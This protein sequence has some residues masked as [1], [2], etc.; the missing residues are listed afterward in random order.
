MTFPVFIDGEWRESQSVGTFNA[1]NPTTGESLSEQYPI[2]SEAELETALQAGARAAMG[3]RA[4]PPEAIADF[5]EAY[6]KAI[7]A[8][9]D[10]LVEMAFTETA[11][12][13]EPR[14]RTTEIPRTTN[15]LRQAAA[16][17]RERSWCMATIDS[18]ANIRSKYGPLGGPV[19]VMGPNNFPYAFN[20]I[21]GG[22]FAA[23]LAAGNPVIAKAHTAHPATTRLLAEAAVEALQASKLPRGAIQ[24]VYHMPLDAGYRIVAHPLLGATAFTGSR[25]G[26]MRLKAAADAAGKPIY[27]EMS[28]INPVFMLPGSLV[29]RGAALA[30]EFSGSCL[31]GT[32]QFCTNPGLVLLVQNEQGE[33]FFE[34]VRRDFAAKPAGI[35][36]TET[37]ARDL[38]ASIQTLQQSGAAVVSGGKPGTSRF[39][40]ENT[41]LRVSARAFIEQAEAL[42]TEA[43]GPASVF[44]FA[45]DEDELIAT[46]KALHGNLTGTIYSDTTGADD[47]LY[48]RIE[49]IL[50]QKV[51]RLLNDKM[52][53]GVAVSPAMNHGGP[54]PSTGHPGFTAVGIPASM[55][56]FGMLQS[57]DNVRA[58]RLPPELGDK[59]PN[60]TMW[61]RIDGQWTR[62]DVGAV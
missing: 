62:A 13:R 61:R 60:G 57:Y 10:A 25:R 27:V 51:G 4:T 58:G 6:A 50:R 36:L 23:A 34:A 29:E 55:L 37:G 39:V 30:S 40:F 53:T 33:A 44:V 24:L 11:L 38:A 35:L 16:A 20:G 32:G 49:P 31:L 8:R 45:K 47:A 1:M 22:D 52:P 7:E 43:F 28:S 14:L 12:P 54:Y 19:L 46:A 2:S 42:Q 5:L 48:A 18:K 56:R 17:A 59:N 41:L 3:L 21:S 26:G 15:Q 9:V